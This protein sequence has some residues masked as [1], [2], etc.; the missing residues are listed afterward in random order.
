MQKHLEPPYTVDWAQFHNSIIC[1][2]YQKTFL[3][4]LFS[5][6]KALHPFLTLTDWSPRIAWTKKY[7][8][9]SCHF[10][11][12]FLCSSDCKISILAILHAACP[13]AW[14]KANEQTPCKVVQ[15]YDPSLCRA[16]VG[17]FQKKNQ[18]LQW[19]CVST[20]SHHTTEWKFGSFALDRGTVAAILGDSVMWQHALFI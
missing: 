6:A 13:P 3:S 18:H 9:L 11:L 12:S 15:A 7:S 16:R 4:C 17:I 2:F 19:A 14:V 10:R 1:S 5:Y 8:R 20:C